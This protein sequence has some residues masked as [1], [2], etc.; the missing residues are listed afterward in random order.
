[1]RESAQRIPFDRIGR[2][3]G[4]VHDPSASV[5]LSP[6]SSS[7]YDRGGFYC[8]VSAP[9][10][11][12]ARMNHKISAPSPP[13]TTSYWRDRGRGGVW[14]FLLLLHVGI[15]ILYITNRAPQTDAAWTGFPLDDTWI[16]MVYGRSLI[17]QGIP[18][19]NTGEPEA[20][21]TSPL[22]MFA[23]ALAHAVSFTTG[24]SIS[25]SIKMIGILFAW[26]A[27]VGAYELT[28][29]W[30]RSHLYGLFAGALTAATPNLSFAQVSG[31]ETPAAVAS[32]I[33]C[34]YHFDKKSYFL[35]GLFLA[36]AYWSRPELV[37]LAPL[38]IGAIGLTILFRRNPR[39]LVPLAKISMPLALAGLIWSVYCVSISGKP[40]PNTYY[41]K[42]KGK[43][44]HDIPTVLLEF[45]WDAPL[46]FIGND[47]QDPAAIVAAGW[48]NPTSFLGVGLALYAIGAVALLTRPTPNRIVTLV[49]P[50]MF[51]IAIPLSRNLML[52]G[53]G[54]YFFTSRYAIPA[55]PLLFI[56]VAVGLDFL[57][58]LPAAST[59]SGRR[60]GRAGLRTVRTIVMIAML[61]CTIRIPD[62]LRRNADLYAW[63]CQN[64]NE[65]QVA[66]GQWVSKNTRPEDVIVVN[67]AGA[68]RY[69]G[70]RR[71]IDLMGL[72]QH[73]LALHAEQ[74]KELASTPVTMR[75]FMNA[76]R[77]R[78]LIIFR[79]WFPPLVSHPDFARHF[80][81]EELARSP[82]Y[83]IVPGDMAEMHVYRL[84]DR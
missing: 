76:H 30:V 5:L 66:L 71:T 53:C 49:F 40:L 33:W 42:V 84:I 7:L 62:A 34:A 77:G 25:I 26:L 20:G 38:L 82:T 28:R 47:V 60:N 59:S 63:N 83:T 6:I 58:N 15:A 24:L 27:S 43:N 3:K 48:N 70:N 81:F 65:V 22:W 14:L 54:I 36:A 16:H 21:F 44:W 19:Y 2:I 18:A 73:E 68:L 45:T 46:R 37:L 4:A 23:S 13:A 10:K 12:P 67:D 39:C 52:P 72:N 1:M 29:R 56:V 78:Y 8:F 74:R 64:I 80:R 17:E 50:W 61:L 32:L 75:E 41:A 35:S 31:M 69:F 57:W 55:I 9:W 11:R 51:L 79:S